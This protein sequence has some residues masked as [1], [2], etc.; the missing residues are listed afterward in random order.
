LKCTGCSGV[1][2]AAVAPGDNPPMADGADDLALGDAV[3]LRDGARIRVRPIEAEDKPALVRGFE[4]LSQD[5]VYNRFLS[6]ISQLRPMD[7]VY[8]TEV[9]HHDHEALIAFDERSGEPVGVVRYVRS[10]TDPRRAEFAVTVVDEWQRRGVGTELLQRLSERARQEGV[11]TF[12]ALLLAENHEMR[13]L[14]EKLGRFRL[15]GDASSVIEAEG[16]L[17]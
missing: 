10:A 16:D 1:R 6:P 13:G 4:R 11:K 14:L 3:T 12:T 17:G 15:K 7:L 8:L 9:D 5:S 2:S